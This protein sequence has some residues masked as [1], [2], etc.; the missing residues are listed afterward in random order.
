MTPRLSVDFAGEV[1]TVDQHGSVT[2]GRAGTIAIDDNPYL[3]RE[4]LSFSH[5][6]GHWWV[7]NVGSMLSAHLTDDQRLVRSTLAS[8]ARM[9]LVFPR[10]AVTFAAGHTVYEL[11]VS[12]NQASYAMVPYGGSSSAEGTTITPG[13]LTETQLLCILALAEPFLRRVGTGPGEVPSAVAAAQRLGWRQTRFNRKLDN[14]C[15]RLSVGGVSGL[16]PENRGA[17]HNRRI[18]LVEYAVSTRLVTSDDLILLERE[19]ARQFSG[20]GD[21]V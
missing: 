7:A 19:A 9:P 15:E 5:D 4:F 18:N 11:S 16:T 1:H 6:A 13:T 3:H 2:V 17:S 20:I 14:V 10:T 8:G 12:T 21:R